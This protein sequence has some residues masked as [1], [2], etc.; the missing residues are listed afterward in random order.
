MSVIEYVSVF[1]SIV[2]GLAVAELGSRCCLC[3]TSASIK[4]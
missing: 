2:L 4:R 1:V 3:A